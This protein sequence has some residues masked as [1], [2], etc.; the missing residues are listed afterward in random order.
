MDGKKR[1]RWKGRSRS[2]SRC[3]RALEKKRE[4]ERP[5]LPFALK[6]V[7]DSSENQ[8]KWQ[9]ILG[10]LSNCMYKKHSFQTLTGDASQRQSD[11][12]CDQWFSAYAFQ[13]PEVSTSGIKI[14]IAANAQPWS[15]TLCL[16]PTASRVHF[17]LFIRAFDLSSLLLMHLMT[18]EKMLKQDKGT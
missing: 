3:R 12:F 6:H 2:R 5:M 15:E 1:A 11:D 16:P 4:R 14:K 18:A 10:S 13:A 17:T 7:S 9:Q 8:S